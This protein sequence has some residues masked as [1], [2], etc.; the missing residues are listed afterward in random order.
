MIRAISSLAFSA[1]I[2]QYGR[3]EGSI[4]NENV[5]N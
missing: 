4:N 5:S 3:G 2:G 1:D